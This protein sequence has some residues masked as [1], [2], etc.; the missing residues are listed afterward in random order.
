VHTCWVTVQWRNG[1]GVRPVYTY[2]SGLLVVTWL[3]FVDCIRRWC[4]VEG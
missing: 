2:V 3:E 4:C 1:A